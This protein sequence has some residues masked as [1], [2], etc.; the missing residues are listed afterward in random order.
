VG[1]ASFIEEP[2]MPF[3]ILV[4]DDQQDTAN[5]LVRLLKLWRFEDCRALYSGKEALRT[6][7]AYPPSA[8]LI[9]IQMPGM[10]GLRL[11]KSIREAPDLKDLPLIAIW[12]YVDEEHRQLAL[13]AGYDHFLAKPFDFKELEELLT[14]VRRDLRLAHREARRCIPGA[15]GSP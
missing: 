2:A 3:R 14:R 8:M 4:V 7:I 15:S 12:G 6:A 5:T 11:A 10:D 1:K 9:D 13:E